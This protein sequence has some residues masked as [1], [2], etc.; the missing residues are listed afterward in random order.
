M[1]GVQVVPLCGM[2]C[3]EQVCPYISTVFL[4]ALIFLP[5]AT[6][7]PQVAFPF[8]SQVPPVARVESPF[9]FTFSPT[10]FKPN[11]SKFQYS[12]AGG[13]AWLQFDPIHHMLWG[14]PGTAD[15]GTT[16]FTITASNGGG[17]TQMPCTLI[18]SSDPAPTSNADVSGTL[19]GAGNM[20]GQRS[21]L[22]HPSQGFQLDFASNAFDG[23]GEELTFYATL[24]DH[25][26]LPSWL[27]FDPQS[28]HFSGTPPKLSSSPQNFDILLVASDVVGFAGVSDKFTITVSDH[29]WAFDPQDQTVN[30]P[31]G[32]SVDIDLR[33]S[34]LSD[35]GKA[36]G[37][38]LSQADADVPSWLT[39]DSQSLAITGSP[40]PAV[41]QL[42]LKITAYDHHGDIANMTLHL[43]FDSL[44]RG[45][46]GPLEVQ[47]GKEFQYT[48]QRSLL[49]QPDSIV[50]VDLGSASSWLHFDPSSLHFD[51]EAPDNAQTGTISANITVTT[52]DHSTTDTRQL[53]VYVRS[54]A[55]P[56]VNSRPGATASSITSTASSSRPSSIVTTASPNLSSKAKGTIAAV[57][58]CPLIGVLAIIL[59]VLYCRCLKR[60]KKPP[61]SPSKADISRPMPS[62]QNGSAIDIEKISAEPRTPEPPPTLPLSFSPAKTVTRTPTRELPVASRRMTARSRFRRSLA[63]LILEENDVET[64]E[65]FDRSSWGYGGNAEGSHNPHD[66]MKIPTAMARGS[67]LPGYLSGRYSDTRSIAFGHLK[68]CRSNGYRRLTGRGHG[69]TSTICEHCGAGNLTGSGHGRASLTN[70]M[71]CGN[72]VSVLPSRVQDCISESSE[73][74]QTTSM[75]STTPSAFPI[76]PTWKSN[77]ASKVPRLSRVSG[78]LRSARAET[79]KGSESKDVASDLPDR[80]DF[81]E[82]R[83]S[84]IYNRAKNRSPFFASRRGSSSSSRGLQT[85]GANGTGDGAK[86]STQSLRRTQSQRPLVREYSASSSLE[87][88]VQGRR[89]RERRRGIA[90][91]WTDGFP[92]AISKVRDSISSTLR[93]EDASEPECERRSLSIYS[94]DQGGDAEAGASVSTSSLSSEGDL[95]TTSQRIPSGKPTTNPP[96]GPLPSIPLK[97]PR[98]QAHPRSQTQPT[99]GDD[100][101]ILDYPPHETPTIEEPSLAVSIRN[102]RLSQTRTKSD[103]LGTKKKRKEYPDLKR[104]SIIDRPRSSYRSPLMA[105]SN[106]NLK[107]T[108]AVNGDK[109]AKQSGAGAEE[110]RGTGIRK[111]KERADGNLRGNEAFL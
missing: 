86:S 39:F 73:W 15:I 55:S 27:S 104:A 106:S 20:T 96:L 24:A 92:R 62:D 22:V 14:T 37:T 40:P 99:L 108:G 85:S 68:D 19:K 110:S 41:K 69:R 7:A 26:P 79:A 89:G 23:D 58:V 72:R 54:A 36:L 75:L 107:L 103:T 64:L 67:N 11:G 98:R 60:R 90:A 6:A 43:R 59:I 17:S 66:S 61:T 111:G 71:Y 21:L 34:L 28:L 18:V 9:S 81:Y 53:E 8:N 50:S 44:F 13:P 65:N 102:A 38:D 48:I 32:G 105:K 10:T 46:I 74:T 35:S 101:G 97:S 57:V 42:D 45:E 47:I 31:S 2:T 51:G 83:Q 12:M 95:D 93:F 87:P 29:V 94:Q 30:I 82:K 25:T 49:A 76:P 109:V 5:C 84:Y 77:S 33:S 4:A 63:S 91:R 52:A 78:T 1:R 70:C 16:K 80:R 100:D 88:S 3:V 56:P